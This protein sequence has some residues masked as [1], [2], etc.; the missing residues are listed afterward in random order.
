[1]EHLLMMTL[2]GST[3][4]VTCWLLRFLLR[5]RISAR[6]YYLLAKAAVLYY[7][8]PLPFLKGWYSKVLRVIVPEDKMEIA[9]ISLARI[10]YMVNADGSVYVNRY[11]KNQIGMVLIWLTVAIFLMARRLVK[12]FRSV[13]WIAG[14]TSTKMTDRQ[15]TYIVGLKEEYGIRRNVLLYQG[16][17]GDSSMTFGIYRPVIICGREVGSREAEL[18]IRHELV[19]IKRL[20]ALWKM[21][22]QF[23]IFLHWCNPVMWSLYFALD[24]FCE[25]SCD[26]TVMRGK[27]K[28]E[29]DEYL[30][31]L[32][33]EAQREEEHKKKKISLKWKVG[34]SSS[35]RRV[36]E[37]MDNLMKNKRW[38]RF[39]VG[40]LVAALIFA[41]SMTAFAY[42]D[43]ASETIQDGASQEHIEKVLESDMVLFEPEETDG[44]SIVDFDMP[45]EIEIQYDRQFTDE[46]GNIYPVPEVEPQW[47]CDHDYVSGTETRH[48]KNSDGSCEVTQYKA[49]R[50]SKC[51]HLVQGDLISSHYYAVCPH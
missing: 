14:Y 10:N 9:H 24:R 30:L 36:R 34:F 43:A 5:N 31:L 33:E 51:G 38:N 6:S 32:I 37:R 49:Q 47:G 17:T 35:M 3:M 2:S 25:L 40:T 46:E 48:N 16:E 22:M 13:R 29:V 44:E 23:V 21:F 41:N 42:R 45:E 7:L 1:M 26:E 39:A 8:I 50:C 20:D 18:L 11:A 27:A 28:T 4:T 15:K 19:H 12:Y